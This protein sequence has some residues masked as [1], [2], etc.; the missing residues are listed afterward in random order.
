MVRLIHVHA[1]EP[2][3]LREVIVRDANLGTF[4]LRVKAEKKRGRNPGWSKLVA[5]DPSVRG[6]INIE[7]KASQRT[8]LCSVNTRGASDGEPITSLFLSYLRATFGD[9]VD[10]RDLGS[11]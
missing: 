2:R 6:A 10:L 4:G 3:S 8:L 1:G 11:P 5:T 9:T 7:W